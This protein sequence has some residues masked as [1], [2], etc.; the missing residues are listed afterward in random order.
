MRLRKDRLAIEQV[1]SL[2]DRIRTNNAAME[3]IRMSGVS[4]GLGLSSL[5]RIVV[6]EIGPPASLREMVSPTTR[7]GYRPPPV[8]AQQPSA[9]CPLRSTGQ[10]PLAALFA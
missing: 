5:G 4:C 9:L 2:D 8:A 3:S 7:P 1:T 10:D 6:G